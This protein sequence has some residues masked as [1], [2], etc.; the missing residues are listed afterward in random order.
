MTL[1]IPIFKNFHMDMITGTDIDS[2]V[3][4]YPETQKTPAETISFIKE[5]YDI[6]INTEK[7]TVV[8]VSPYVMECIIKLSRRL[9][10]DNK[11]IIYT[12]GE[13]E[14]TEHEFWKHFAEPMQD[15]FFI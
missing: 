8:S 11:N 1:I 7:I 13:K 6:N 10:S 12:D 5:W 2:T 15:I 3:L 9:L 14:I 4:M